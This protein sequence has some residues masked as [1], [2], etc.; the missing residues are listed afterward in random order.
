MSLLERWPDLLT[1]QEAAEILRTDP[2]TVDSLIKIGEINRIE[3]AGK[4]LIPRAFLENFIAKS[5]KM[6]YNESIETDTPVPDSQGQQHLD[7]C[8]V[9]IIL[10]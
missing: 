3:I 1:L 4:S 2:A 10:H 5:S 7:N 6:C 9:Y 8:V